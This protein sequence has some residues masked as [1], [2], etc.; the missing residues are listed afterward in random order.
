M[1]IP[2][3]AGCGVELVAETQSML[4]QWWMTITLMAKTED[5]ANWHCTNSS[6][7]RD[8][9]ATHSWQ[10]CKVRETFVYITIRIVSVP[11][12]LSTIVSLSPSI[13]LLS[14]FLCVS[15]SLFQSVNVHAHAHGHAR[16]CVRVC[17]CVCAQVHVY[18][19]CSLC[20]SVYVCASTCMW[21]MPFYMCRCMY[22]C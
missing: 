20:K 9:T 11:L 3:I 14:P 18:F 8:N 12:R 5:S 21:Y 19:T 15:P 16:A 22:V 13:S 10:T 1:S 7:V 2:A 6:S 17:V 4:G